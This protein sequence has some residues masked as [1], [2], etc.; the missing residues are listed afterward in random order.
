MLSS[1]VYWITCKMDVTCDLLCWIT[2]ILA[3][4]LVGLKSLTI[5]LDYRSYMSSSVRIW[6][7]RWLF[8][9]LCS[10]NLDSSVTQ[11]QR[12]V[13][14]RQVNGWAPR[15]LVQTSSVQ[16]Q[17]STRVALARL[18]DDRTRTLEW[19]DSGPQSPVE[20][21]KLPERLFCDRMQPPSDQATMLLLHTRDADVRTDRTLRPTSGAHYTSVWSVFLSEK[22]HRDFTT[23]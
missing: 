10:Y 14:T 17:R 8:L 16:L 5:S 9:Y 19:S 18:S 3:C 2:T 4:I 22:H 23:S 7:L 20:S 12:L 1:D 21:S 6:S 11:P 13:A 15:V